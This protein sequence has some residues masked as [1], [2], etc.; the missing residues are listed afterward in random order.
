MSFEVN[1]DA[2][3]R[4]SEVDVTIQ[5]GYLLS[6]EAHDSTIIRRSEVTTLFDV[7]GHPVGGRLSDDDVEQP[8]DL[9]RARCKKRTIVGVEERT[10]NQRR[11]VV[12]LLEQSVDEEIEQ[13]RRQR[14]TL[15]D[16]PRAEEPVRGLAIGDNT[17]ADPLEGETCDQ[18]QHPRQTA[19]S[20]EDISEEGMVDDIESGLEVEKDDVSDAVGLE[21][22]MED[23]GISTRRVVTTESGLRRLHSSLAR[24]IES[25]EE[26][27]LKDL[28]EHTDESDGSDVIGVFGP[29]V[30]LNDQ[31]D[32]AV[33]PHP[34]H[35][36]Q[37]NA[38]VE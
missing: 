28:P 35:T 12:Q 33:V 5:P 19:P 21:E 7:Q 8:L 37:P 6:P 4:E 3:N 20:T 25:T 22:R 36:S 15:K 2:Y 27:V 11:A 13:T 23:G 17:G 16:T 18:G 38:R 26:Q 9:G 1:P 29:G 34:R 10:G 31:T 14:R 32:H 30:I 24:S